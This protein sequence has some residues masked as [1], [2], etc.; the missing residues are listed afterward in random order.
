MPQ[1]TDPE[2]IQS[3]DYRVIP[4]SKLS[5]AQAEDLD[6]LLHASL[7]VDFP[8]RTAAEIEGFVHIYHSRHKNLNRHLGS[9][10]LRANQLYRHQRLAVA[11]DKNLDRAVSFLFFADNASS[12][13]DI[14]I[15]A[16]LSKVMNRVPK[17]AE[18]L[19]RRA[20]IEAKLRT[21]RLVTKRWHWL[22][23]RAV[24]PELVP[25]ETSEADSKVSVV[26][27]LG[28]LSLD[29]KNWVQPVS[30]YPWHGEKWWMESLSSWGLRAQEDEETEPIYA[31]GSEQQPVL[32]ER[33]VAE[34][35]SAVDA[36]LR[37]KPLGHML[38]SEAKQKAAIL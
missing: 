27:V 38:L 28:Y 6:E 3:L 35:V 11:T 14:E 21:E 19:L 12:T 10:S 20:E 30:A 34:S 15:P 7:S 1:F 23:M 17:P 22:G 24:L 33:W 31:F 16:F 18:S 26:D 32:Q 8:D 37:S 25:E 9:A 36:H 13:R 2:Y 29:G 4:A 5:S